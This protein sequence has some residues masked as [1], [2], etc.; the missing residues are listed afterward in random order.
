M[1]CITLL[2]LKVSSAPHA[3]DALLQVVQRCD[4]LRTVHRA[5]EVD[6]FCHFGTALSMYRKLDLYQMHAVVT[7]RLCLALMQS[8]LGALCVGRTRPET[9]G[10]VVEFQWQR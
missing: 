7:D 3:E 5:T 9:Q 4:K 10:R 6:T 2:S 8:T 1:P